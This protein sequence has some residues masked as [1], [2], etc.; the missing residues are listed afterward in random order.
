MNLFIFT[1]VF[2]GLLL[3][4]VF[5]VL[6]NLLL[7]AKDITKLIKHKRRRYITINSKIETNITTHLINAF[8]GSFVLVSLTLLAISLINLVSD[9]KPSSQIDRHQTTLIGR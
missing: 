5:Y 4:L 2:L 7:L 6:H 3:Y 9:P 1:L 8:L